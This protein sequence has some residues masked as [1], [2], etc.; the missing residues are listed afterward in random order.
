[1]TAVNPIILVDLNSH[2]LIRPITVDH[3]ALKAAMGWEVIIDRF[4]LG[5]AVIPYGNAVN[6]PRKTAGILRRNA[7]LI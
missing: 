6:I 1:M 4:M 5:T 3:N 2:D 7:V